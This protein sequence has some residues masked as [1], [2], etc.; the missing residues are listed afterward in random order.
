M[1]ALWKSILAAEGMRIFGGDRIKTSS[2]VSQYS[3]RLILLDVMISDWWGLQLLYILKRAILQKY[4][5]GQ[6]PHNHHHA[7][8][9]LSLH[10]L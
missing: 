4:V 7:C 5:K 3:V 6:L 9:N 1:F 8:P 10:S 2:F